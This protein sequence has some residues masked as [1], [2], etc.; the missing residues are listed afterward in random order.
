MLRPNGVLGPL[1]GRGPGT[2]GWALRP[3]R[4]PDSGSSEA[5]PEVPRAPRARPRLGSGAGRVG[6][7]AELHS[8]P[9]PPFRTAPGAPWLRPTCVEGTHGGAAS[10]ED[11]REVVLALGLP[12][13]GRGWGPGCV[14]RLG[15]RGPCAMSWPPSCQALRMRPVVPG[16]GSHPTAIGARLCPGRRGPRGEGAQRGGGLRG[17]RGGGPRGPWGAVNLSHHPRG[18]GLAVTPST[19]D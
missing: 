15:Q 8:R 10:L 17:E 11:Q 12:S 14:G 5:T 6:G 4:E 2:A 9:L 18:L 7:G 19:Q 3:P 16:A 13:S 1:Q